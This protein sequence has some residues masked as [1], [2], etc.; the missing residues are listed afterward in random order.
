ML[1]YEEEEKS[2]Y[3]ND[4]E[5][6]GVKEVYEVLEVIF[7]NF[8]RPLRLKS[9]KDATRN[10]RRIDDEDHSYDLVSK[11]HCLDEKKTNPSLL[12]HFSDAGEYKFIIHNGGL[13]EPLVNIT[14]QPLVPSPQQQV[15]YPQPV[16]PPLSA[17][18]SGQNPLLQP[19]QQGLLPPSGVAVAPSCPPIRRIPPPPRIPTPPCQS[20]FHPFQTIFHPLFR[21]SVIVQGL[22]LRHSNHSTFLR[23][24]ICIHSR[25]RIRIRN[26]N[27]VLYRIIICIDFGVD[28]ILISV[29]NTSPKI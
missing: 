26:R 25:S 7:K 9:L 15:M 12:V 24:R 20:I 3:T 10:N 27:I 16:V 28:I 4:I 1:R 23:S 13:V 22:I 19:D 29:W 8:K 2:E 18:T 21:R 17:S 5:P 11:K 6:I 14:Q